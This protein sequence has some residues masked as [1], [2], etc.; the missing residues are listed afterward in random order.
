MRAE[1]PFDKIDWSRPWL[2][3]YRDMAADVVDKD[4]WIAELNRRAASDGL[5]NHRG[6]PLR[7]VP[8]AELPPDT[9]YEAFISATGGV[10]TRANL[11]DFFNGLVWLTFPLVKA[12]LN[13]LQSVQIARFGVGRAR[14]ATRDAA[15]IFDENAAILITRDTRLAPSLREHHW[16]PLFLQGREA[17]MRDT[18]TWLFGHALIEKLV[19]PYKAIT[20]HA[21]VLPV[22]EG[23]FSLPRRDRIKWTDRELAARQAQQDPVTADFTP[24]PVLGVPG[25]WEP[26]DEPFYADAAVFRAKRRTLR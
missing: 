25:W 1:T 22:E 5:R 7:F 26:Q 14:G 18:E 12:Q 2:A 13:R 8:Q 20:A 24:L 3:I 6:L 21:W 17:F 15:T 10:P 4:D 9:S 16:R 11:H 23:F 19:T